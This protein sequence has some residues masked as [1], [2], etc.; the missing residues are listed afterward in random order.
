MKRSLAIAV[1]AS[2]F[3]IAVS[4]CAPQTEVIKLHDETSSVPDGFRNYLVVAVASDVDTRREFE[5]QIVGRIREAGALATAAYTKTGPQTELLQEEIDAAARETSAD[6]IL[7]THIVSVDTTA[8]MQQ[9]RTDV[10][11]EC[12]GGDPEDYF[13]YDYEML[14]EPDSV[15]IAHTVVAITNLYDTGSGSRLWTI[16]STCFEK[17][18]M[19]EVLSEEAEAIARQLVFDRL[20]G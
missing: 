12:R 17:A 7:I 11:A 8:E 20:I 1:S 6:A 14:K 5:D 15:R 13:L 2:I 4:A 10:L 19:H 16:Q 9:G 3:A 18:T